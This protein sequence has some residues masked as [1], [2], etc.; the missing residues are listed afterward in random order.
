MSPPP[1]PLD[2]EIMSLFSLTIFFKFNLSL[3]PLLLSE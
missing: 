2:V 1:H 3:F